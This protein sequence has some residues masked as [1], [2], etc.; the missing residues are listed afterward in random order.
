MKPVGLISTEFCSFFSEPLLPRTH[1][2]SNTNRTLSTRNRKSRPSLKS[3]NKTRTSSSTLSNRSIDL[4]SKSNT[5][6]KANSGSLGRVIAHTTGSPSTALGSNAAATTASAFQ[7]TVI[8]RTLVRITRSA[9]TATPWWWLADIPGSSTAA[10]AS[11]LLTRGQNT[12]QTTGTTT[13][14]CISTTPGTA[15][16]CTTVGIPEIESQSPSS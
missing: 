12:G 1:S 14:T 6:T 15:I 7:R 5:G 11:V 3:S 16:T 13:M 10:S 2:R 9:S 4:H 8:V